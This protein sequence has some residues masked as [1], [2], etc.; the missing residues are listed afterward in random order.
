MSAIPG[1]T[2]PAVDEV[3]GV[4]NMDGTQAMSHFD[5]MTKEQIEAQLDRIQ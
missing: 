3:A 5:G 2:A 4:A 1:G